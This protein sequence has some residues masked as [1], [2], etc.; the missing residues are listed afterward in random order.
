M[1]KN[2]NQRSRI[3][4]MGQNFSMYDKFVSADSPEKNI[5]DFS[6]VERPLLQQ[7]QA[8]SNGFAY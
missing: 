8:Q 6:N 4:K 2:D 3:N 1:I 5:K 7:Y